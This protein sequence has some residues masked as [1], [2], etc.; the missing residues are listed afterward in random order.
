MIG[1]IIML[2]LTMRIR[3]LAKETGR[4]PFFWVFTALISYLGTQSFIAVVFVFLLNTIMQEH[5]SGKFV[6]PIV[7]FSEFFS[8]LSVWIIASYL[9][10]RRG[11][12]S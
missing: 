10:E 1:L 5:L 11:D 12:K 3:S 6:L 2:M 4:S 7:F 8:L 9:N